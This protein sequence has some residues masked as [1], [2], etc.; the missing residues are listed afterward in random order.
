MTRYER[1]LDLTEKKKQCLV[2]YKENKKKNQMERVSKL[3]DGG[4]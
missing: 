2:A 4:L 1:Y 3:G